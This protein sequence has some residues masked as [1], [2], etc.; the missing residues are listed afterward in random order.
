MAAEQAAPM[1]GGTE[2]GAVVAGLARAEGG[3]S[4]RHSISGESPGF[5]ASPAR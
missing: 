2:A 1:R 5:G 3:M 4:L